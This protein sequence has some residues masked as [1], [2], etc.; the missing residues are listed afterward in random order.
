[1]LTRLSLSNLAIIEKAEIDFS[2]GFNALTGE[3]GAGKSVIINALALILGARADS[4]MVR[5]GEKQAVI[6]AVFDLQED[7]SAIHQLL[8]EAGFAPCE[9][10]Q[11]IIRRIILS[12]GNG[13][14][15]VND[16]SATAASLRQ[17][18]K[19]LVDIHGP[20]ANQ[21]ILEESF[22]RASLDSYGAIKL[23]EY[24]KIWHELQKLRSKIEELS[25][26]EADPARLETLRYDI[27][28]LENAS[29]DEED[30]DIS[31]RHAAAAH[32]EEIIDCGNQI[33]AA[34]AGDDG[35]ATDTL[36]KLRS[37]F[38]LLA[39]RIPE[40][41]KWEEEVFRINSELIGI[42]DEIAEKIGSF[43]IDEEEFARLDE[44][45]GLVNRLKR[46]YKIVPSDDNPFSRQ[47]AEALSARKEELSEFE[48]REKLLSELQNEEA[49]L[50][51]QV[52]AA[53][54]KVTRERMRQG[55]VLSKKVTDALKDLGFLQSR[56]FVKINGCEPSSHGCDEVV[57]M[58]EPNPGEGAR[59]LADIASSGE[60]ARVML[61]LK[62]VLAANDDVD[63]L[64][65]DEIDA[66]IG[67]E[68]GLA[69][70]RKMRN[71]AQQRQV[72]SITHL[73]QCAV[74]ANNHLKVSKAV[75]GGRT[76][77]NVVKI[78][79]EE[80]INEISRMLGGEAGSS[81]VVGAHA[82]ELIAQ[83]DSLNNNIKNTN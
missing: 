38:S 63:T 39:K 33:A 21:R 43:D 41:K 78:E 16:S 3:T 53:G 45:L 79:G 28:E 52:L 14:I 22:Q 59:A 54:A 82:K 61:A 30:D 50:K 83:A 81:N 75:I 44:R 26:K 1:M 37:S 25:G 6:E 49:S 48:N 62:S 12:S 40:A 73:P 71:V 72:I 31:Q 17:I 58:L 42:S 34:L 2:S 64:I 35:S 11:L 5:D 36:A 57:F 77:T 60:I 7:S 18:G 46:K 8:E 55:E 23:D 66:N 4:S 70:G 9:D 27:D 47:I 51:R 56:F 10:S 15:F 24:E 32:A 80:R 68:T 67:G 69:V 74:F 19:F 76:K 29:I 20:R 65:F 13:R